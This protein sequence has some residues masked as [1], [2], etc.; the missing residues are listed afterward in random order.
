VGTGARR[1]PSRGSVLALLDLRATGPRNTIAIGLLE[2]TSLP[3]IVTATRA[4]LA[5]PVAAAN[6]PS[7]I[8]GKIRTEQGADQGGAGDRA[9]FAEGHADLVTKAPERS[10]CP[11]AVGHRRSKSGPDEAGRFPGQHLDHPDRQAVWASGSQFHP[12][13]AGPD[14]V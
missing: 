9:D 3:F 10:G 14:D 8:S 13:G 7:A 12:I 6:G 11:V 2:A 4:C 5:P 1:L